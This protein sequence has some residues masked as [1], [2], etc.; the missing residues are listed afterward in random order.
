MTDAVSSQP[1]KKIIAVVLALFSAILAVFSF[2]NF[3]FSFLA[4]F[5]LIPLL[6]ALAK[7]QK[8]IFAFLLGELFAIGYFYGTCYWITYSMI[9][10]GELPVLVA[11]L[12]ALILVAI[13][14]LFPALF[15]LLINHMVRKIGIEA[16]IF[17]P[18]VWVAT[19]YLRL[20][21][22]GVGWNAFGY[23]QS[24]SPSLI[25]PSRFGGVFLVS[26]LV[27]LCSSVITLIFLKRTRLTF[28]IFSVGV[29]I[30]LGV[31]VFGKLSI[32][33]SLSLSPKNSINVVAAQAV[34]PVNVR[35]SEL[36]GSL[37]LQIEL[38]LQ[39]VAKLR[40]TNG[41][42]EGSILVAWPEAPFN[43]AYDRDES[44]KELFGEFTRKNKIYLL[45]NGESDT[46]DKKGQ[47]NSV[48]LINPEGKRTGQYNKIHLLPFGEYVPMR[49]YLP[50]IHLIP[51][52]A[53]DYTAD[54]KYSILEIEGTKLG[55]FICFESVFPDITRESARN[56][57][58]AFINVANDG[59]FGQTPISRQHLAHV[60]MRAVETNRP[61]LR[62]TNVGISAYIDQNGLI[63]DETPVFQP[64]LRTWQIAKIREK[65]PLTFYTRFGDLFA[66]ACIL[67]NVLLLLPVS[68]IFRRKI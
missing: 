23:S 29:L 15:A 24:F 30:C 48:I 11:H 13:V 41:G 35:E 36:V 14:S 5:C 6:Y 67:I 45:F 34:A 58:T 39:G 56:G 32:K 33:E 61:L 63:K 25:W 37:N 57:A 4:W 59:W 53:G 54:S 47:H 20:H 51:A 17:A 1:Q 8:P 42:E 44:W 3:G 12:L 19:E 52:L 46:E 43:F 31:F 62:V 38:S 65:L 9:N 68:K 7:P 60:V 10:Y 18:I 26:A 49:G 16:L 27:V 28:S 22:F 2:P 66:F 50:F 21:V 40:E 55:T 64:A